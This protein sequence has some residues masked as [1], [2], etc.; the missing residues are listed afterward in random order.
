LLSGVFALMAFHSDSRIFIATG[1]LVGA[2]AG[3]LYPIGLAILG[4]AV[5]KKRLGAA[6]SLFSLAFGVGSLVGPSLA[7]L[8]MVHLGN[9]WLFYLPAMLTAFFV[10][11]L[12]AVNGLRLDRGDK[13]MQS[14]DAQTS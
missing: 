8:A 7:G 9:R 3:S 5:N 13:A 12:V 10:V 14:V 11:G 2:L 6:T 4:G 1:A